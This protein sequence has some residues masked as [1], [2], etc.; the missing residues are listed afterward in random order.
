MGTGVQ[1]RNT[2]DTRAEMVN[3]VKK[4]Q[5]AQGKMSKGTS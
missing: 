1:S 2:G 3:G 5:G 4:G